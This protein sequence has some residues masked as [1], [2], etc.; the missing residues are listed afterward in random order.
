MTTT[1]T[2]NNDTTVDNDPKEL[3]VMHDFIIDVSKNDKEML[4]WINTF[5]IDQQY[6]QHIINAFL[7]TEHVLRSKYDIFYDYEPNRDIASRVIDFID[8]E[9]IANDL[10]EIMFYDIV[11][12]AL[13]TQ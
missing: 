1:T 13:L 4:S 6:H 9:K 7:Y 8:N 5:G 10:D 3:L 2:G 11:G 12:T